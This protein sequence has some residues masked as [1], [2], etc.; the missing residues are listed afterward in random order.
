VKRARLKDA[1]YLSQAVNSLNTS[2][3]K[4][5][6]MWLKLVDHQ[7]IARIAAKATP[8]RTAQYYLMLAKIGGHNQTK[9]VV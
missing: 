6:D 5:M 1:S 8:P 7:P 3:V 2:T 9:I 4:T